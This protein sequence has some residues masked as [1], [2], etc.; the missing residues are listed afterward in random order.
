MVLLAETDIQGGSS[1]NR[2][3]DQT[4]TET[5]VWTR[6]IPQN[7]ARTFQKQSGIVSKSLKE[8]VRVATIDNFQVSSLKKTICSPKRIC[9]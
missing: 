1:F 8:F 5:T 9:F 4:P 2:A 7:N 3:E 6:P